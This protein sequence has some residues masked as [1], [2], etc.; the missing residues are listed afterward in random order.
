MRTKAKK[1]GADVS[2][3]R[4]AG[5]PVYV[6]I[7]PMVL[8]VISDEGVEQL[9]TL[10]I[11]VEV[12]DFD[13]ADDMHTNMPRVRDALMRALY[14][15][16]GQGSL[17]NGKLVD[18]VRIKNRATAALNEVIGSDKIREVLVQGISQR[19]L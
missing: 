12:R 1:G 2:G 18:V 19:M 11:D 15:G 3:G 8:P 10:I 4:F 16:L 7:M 14:G 6:H 9:V 17:R 5:D 13:V